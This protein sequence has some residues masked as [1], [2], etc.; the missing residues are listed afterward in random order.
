MYNTSFA[1][2]NK[3]AVTLYLFGI[4]HNT[5]Y[6]LGTVKGLRTLGK[7]VAIKAGDESWVACDHLEV[8]E[9]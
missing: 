9:F 2:I 6:N 3:M 5:C 8:I 1:S 4:S 7:T